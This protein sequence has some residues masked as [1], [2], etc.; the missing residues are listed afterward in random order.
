MKGGSLNFVKRQVK[1]SDF[2]YTIDPERILW[3]K[4]VFPVGE[5]LI[6]TIQSMPWN[7]YRYNGD[8][9]LWHETST[10][11]GYT[12][13][14]DNNTVIHESS[15]GHIEATTQNEL[16][17]AFLGGGAYEV[18]N[19]A[20]KGPGFPLLHD[21]V[22][23][24]GDLDIKLEL[25]EIIRIESDDKTDKMKFL[26]EDREGTIISGFVENYIDWIFNN[27]YKS[28]KVFEKDFD[29]LFPRS[30]DFDYHENH[31]GQHAND[32][33]RIGRLW[34]LKVPLFERGMYK[35]Q[36]TAKF[37]G[38]AN[39]DHM[40]E[41]ILTV[42]NQIQ[43]ASWNVFTPGPSFKPRDV[44]N[45]SLKTRVESIANLYNG[46]VRAMGDRIVAWNTELRHKFYNHVGRLQY[47]NLL[48]PALYLGNPQMHKASLMDIGGQILPLLV[49]LANHKNA[50]TLCQFDYNY[51]EWG[52]C[53]ETEL[54]K[55]II[56]NAK[57]ILFVPSIS[58]VFPIIGERHIPLVPRGPQY[59]TK[60]LLNMLLPPTAGGLR[61]RRT[62]RRNIQRRK[63]RKPRT[64]SK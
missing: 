29:Y 34:L 16:P 32:A 45:T 63:T 50:G 47:L 20:H 58:P 36:L 33:K 30:I 49:L 25:P 48:T 9:T 6:N 22:D 46:N 35:I 31:E 41:F 60:D 42:P 2:K 11:S 28:L 1:D 19:K 10:A 26:F 17:F 44:Y 61:K 23:P 56:G 21:Y 14:E 43:D 18:L 4:N 64:W 13:T 5:L 55:S 51:I 37:D 59:K 53:D 12:L 52:A 7:S 3:V 57:N 27:L 40:L 62:R 39:S 24:T 38:M 15:V 54:I 8:I